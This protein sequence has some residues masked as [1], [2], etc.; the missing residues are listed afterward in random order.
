MGHVLSVTAACYSSSPVIIEL[1]S[2]PL[3]WACVATMEYS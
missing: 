1:L 3:R 2:G